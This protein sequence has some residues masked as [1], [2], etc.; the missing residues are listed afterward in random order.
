V[1]IL[2]VTELLAPRNV[3]QLT[4][5]GPTDFIKNRLRTPHRLGRPNRSLKTSL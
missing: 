5:T 4:R 1:T 2:H 3:R